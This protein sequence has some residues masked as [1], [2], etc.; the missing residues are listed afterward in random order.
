M[1]EKTKSRGLILVIDDEKIILSLI[2]RI[3]LSKGYQVLLASDGVYGLNLVKEQNPDLILLDITMPG[4]DGF[5]T[6]EKIREV[7]NSPVI[8]VTGKQDMESLQRTIDNGADDFIRKPFRPK[9][10]VARI[11]TKLR[12][13]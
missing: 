3:L 10:L 12:R 6:L 2:E 4:L 11:E 7:S 1:Q 8:M 13:I 5:A 9:E